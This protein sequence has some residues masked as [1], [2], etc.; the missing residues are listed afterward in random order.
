MFKYNSLIVLIFLGFLII[1]V[2]FPFGNYCIGMIDGLI[3]LGLIITYGVFF[4]YE[5]FLSHQKNKHHKKPFD[6]NSLYVTIGFIVLFTITR[7]LN[8]F[9]S[10]TILQAKTQD[11]YEYI[12]SLKKNKKFKLQ[13][14]WMDKDCFFSG[15]YE[16]NNDTLRLTGS[17]KIDTLY[18]I[19]Y[20]NQQLKS[21]N[22][23][24]QT[25]LILRIP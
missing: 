21:L 17:I 2:T 12:L 6:T 3:F 25:F 16:I 14:K 9:E 24:K 5:I 23:F 4:I 1:W 8:I 18:F 19:D 10:K 11:R 20:K 15:K 7:N 22:N 13:K